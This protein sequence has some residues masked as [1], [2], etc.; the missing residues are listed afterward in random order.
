MCR[1]T[2]YLFLYID[3][4]FFGTAFKKNNVKILLGIHTE[5][6]EATS[7]DRLEDVYLICPKDNH[8]KIP[9]RIQ[10]IL[11]IFLDKAIIF[12]LSQL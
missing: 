1:G 3:T 8:I 10:T 4:H 5:I 9:P 6:R 11:I 12:L 2:D 7:K